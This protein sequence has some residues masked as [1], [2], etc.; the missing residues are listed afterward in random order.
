MKTELATLTPKGLANVKVYQTV[1]ALQIAKYEF[2]AKRQA[3]ETR[4]GD[5]LSRLQ[6]EY[7]AN[8]V[9]IHSREENI[10]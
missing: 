6:V 7:L 8:V 4:Y 3:L 9:A 1:F 10:A 2:D 5:E